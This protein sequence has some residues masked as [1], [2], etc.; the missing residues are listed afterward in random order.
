MKNPD[1]AQISLGMC[2][3]NL[4]RY[5]DARKEFRKS[6]KVVK[7]RRLSN[8]WLRVIEAEVARNEQ[9]RLAEQA[10]RKKSAEVKARREAANRA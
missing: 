8:Q 4:R 7:S 5:N 9:I 10:A 6:A 1:N 2:L 3:Y